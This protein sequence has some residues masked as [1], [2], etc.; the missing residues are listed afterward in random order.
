[1]NRACLLCLSAPLD[2]YH[3][4]AGRRYRIC[5]ACDVVVL[6]R[7]QLPTRREEEAEYALHRNDP[8]TRPTGATWRN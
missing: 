5:R 4:V 6:G 1:M 7:D 2:L 3:E 8:P